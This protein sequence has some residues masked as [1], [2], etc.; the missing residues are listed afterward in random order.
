[1]GIIVFYSN[2]QHYFWQKILVEVDFTDDLG[3]RKNIKTYLDLK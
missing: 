3:K 1:M 2:L